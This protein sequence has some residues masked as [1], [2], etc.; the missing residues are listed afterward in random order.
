MAEVAVRR[1]G[2]VE[3]AV[4]RARRAPSV[5]RRRELACIV[6]EA[7]RRQVAE[8]RLLR[9]VVDLGEEQSQHLAVCTH[10]GRD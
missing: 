3:R 5:R 7:V 4:R 2:S 1:R 8:I 6:V 10:R 9:R